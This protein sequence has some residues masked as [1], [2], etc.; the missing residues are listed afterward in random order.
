MKKVRITFFGRLIRIA[1]CCGLFL[2]VVNMRAAYADS[3]AYPVIISG[4]ALSMAQI[5]ELIA[6]RIAERAAKKALKKAAAKIAKKAEEAAERAARKAAK[7]AVKKAVKKAAKKAELAADAA[8]K[9]AV[10]KA[11]KEAAG[12]ATKKTAQKA[13]QI[14]MAAA[15]RAVKNKHGNKIKLWKK[16]K[17]AMKAKS[18]GLMAEKSRAF[19]EIHDDNGFGAIGDEI[20]VLL[21]KDAGLNFENYDVM[22]HQYLEGLDMV[23]VRVAIPQGRKS[24][25]TALEISQNVGDGVVDMNHLYIPEAN[26][27]GHENMPDLKADYSSELNLKA[28]NAAEISIGLIDTMI[29]RSHLALQS[30]VILLEDFVPYDQIRPEIHGTAVAS[31]LVGNEPEVFRGLV[32]GAKLY[33]A[34]VFFEVPSGKVA[35]TTESLILALDWL[36]RQKVQVINMS[37]SGPP[38]RLLEIAVKRVD[39][40]GIMIVAAVGN[41][42]PAASPLYP[43]AYSGVV[44]VTAVDSNQH[45]YLRANRGRHITFS[46]PGVNI[47]AARAEG[48]YQARSGTSMAAP[49]VSAILADMTRLGGLQKQDQLLKK[50]EEN[51]VDLGKP[52]FDHTYG[53]GLI[54]AIEPPLS[55]QG[56]LK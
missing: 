52:G 30:E 20:L 15:K 53:Y 51:A 29:D 41:G 7:N 40:K 38:N 5:Q 54:Q 50:L 23:L 18:A 47:P 10:K 1:L 25:D 55:V 22:E 33:A 39:E 36:V 2:S 4:S 3:A 49:F 28:N 17:Q 19:R 27:A 6:E 45:V 9:K 13:E 21:E 46:A 8:T 26:T 48:G 37:L 11:V 42:G 56:A 12:K 35:A 32:H 34:S 24:S 44:A 16:H 43:A 31:I 14:A